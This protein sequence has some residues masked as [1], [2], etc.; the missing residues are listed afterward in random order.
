MGDLLMKDDL[1]T[2]EGFIRE[3]EI[4]PNTKRKI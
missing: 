3:S 1:R 2:P 4:E